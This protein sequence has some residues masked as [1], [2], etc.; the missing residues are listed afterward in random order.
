VAGTR[1]TVEECFET[2]KDEVGLDHNEVRKWGSWYRH[3]TLAL[4]AHAYL[5]VLRAHAVATPAEKGG[6][7]RQRT[8]C[9]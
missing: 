7:R 2:G 5:A 9:R 3:M 8:C 4:L 1:W 6:L